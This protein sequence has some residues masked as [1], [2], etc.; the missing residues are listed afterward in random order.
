MKRSVFG[1]YMVLAVT[2][3]SVARQ[4]DDAPSIT[5][6]VASNSYS[7]REYPDFVLKWMGASTAPVPPN[8]FAR[9]AHK[10]EPPNRAG[11]NRVGGKELDDALAEFARWCTVSGG[12]SIRYAVAR[13]IDPRLSSL[14]QQPTLGLDVGSY[15]GCERS[16]MVI[17]LIH[18]DIDR[19]STNLPAQL[20]VTHYSQASIAQAN[21]TR[22]E[23]ARTSA[24]RSQ[25]SRTVAAKQAQEKDAEFQKSLKIGDV[26]RWNRSFSSGFAAQGLVVEMRPPI[27]LIQFSNVTPS[28]QWVRIDEL[29]RP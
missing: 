19:S 18:V 22:R 28:P 16:S 17:A 23:V 21:E 2:A 3:C 11:Y 26:V 13:G 8:A 25:H 5:R 6:N 4:F 9:H 24:S 29:G 12:T 10:I 15:E 14:L 7:E 27:A 1:I 20:T